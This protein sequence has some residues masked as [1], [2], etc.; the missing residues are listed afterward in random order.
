MKTNSMFCS[1]NKKCREEYSK[2]ISKKM[3]REEDDLE[4]IYKKDDSKKEEK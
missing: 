3:L 4:T 1:L 2:E